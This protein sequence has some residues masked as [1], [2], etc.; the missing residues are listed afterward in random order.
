M[1]TPEA[2]ASGVSRSKEKS[3]KDFPVFT[4][5]NGAASLVLKEIPYRREAYITLRDSRTPQALLEECAAFCRACGAEKVYATGHEILEQLPLHTVMLEM[6]GIPRVDEAF[7]ANLFP[8][9]EPTVAR[10]R[11]LHNQA[12]RNTANVGTLEER[13]EAELL[14]G[15][16]YF[17]HRDGELLGIGWLREETLEVIASAYPGSGK[18]VLHTMASVCPGVPLR[19]EVASTNERA[20]AL[21]EK[22]GFLKVKELSRWYRV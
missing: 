5:E 10:W 9:T 15:G 11:A 18:Y 2:D 16:A 7:I 19:L 14:K 1:F 17:V 4:T 12:M 8:V 6:R 21:Y 22:I 3:M 13:D 20:I